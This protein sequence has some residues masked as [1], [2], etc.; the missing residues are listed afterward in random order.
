MKFKNAV[1]QEISGISNPGNTP[2][3]MIP[4]DTNKIGENQVK[5]HNFTPSNLL[6]QL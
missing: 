1:K 3:L 6:S 2:G 5:S 4:K